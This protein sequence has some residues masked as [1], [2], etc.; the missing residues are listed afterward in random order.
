MGL[1]FIDKTAHTSL[2]SNTVAIAK[3]FAIAL[4]EENYAVL[5]EVQQSRAS[6]HPTNS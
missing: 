2:S 6:S 3:S 5:S 4:D 1:S